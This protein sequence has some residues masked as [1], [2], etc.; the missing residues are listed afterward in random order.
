MTN[1]ILIAAACLMLSADAFAEMKA[2]CS[3]KMS[4]EAKCE[5]MN[6]GAKKDSACV[7]IEIVR[8]YSADTYTRPAFG[9]KGAALVSEQICSGLVEP[10][11]IRERSPSG[12]WSVNGTPM[13]PLAFCDSDNPWFKAATNCT[14]ETKS[15]SK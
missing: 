15:V 3:T 8:A 9:G 2:N 11:D 6:T 12:K 5:F 4:G 1:K 13:T 10:Q 7:V 14:M